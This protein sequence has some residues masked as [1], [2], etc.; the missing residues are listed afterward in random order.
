[1]Q[2]MVPNSRT[3][4]LRLAGLQGERCYQIE[5][6]PHAINIKTAGS[7]LNFVLPVKVNTEGLLVHTAAQVYMLPCERE[8]YTVYG[9][10]LMEAGLRCKQRF[11]GTGYNENVRMMPDFGT[12]MFYLCADAAAAPEAQAASK[13]EKE[14]WNETPEPAQKPEAAVDAPEAAREE[15]V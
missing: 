8:R 11:T 9:D 6:R 14:R 15:E 1:M 2:L 5:V 4:P 10:L 13:Q 3:Q 7:L 12:R